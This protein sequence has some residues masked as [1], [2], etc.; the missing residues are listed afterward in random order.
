MNFHSI[1]T[2]QDILD[3]YHQLYESRNNVSFKYYRIA[4]KNFLWKLP[5]S[6]RQFVCTSSSN[7]TPPRISSNFTNKFN[8]VHHFCRSKNQ[9]TQCFRSSDTGDLFEK[10]NDAAWLKIRV[11]G[12]RF[13]SY[14]PRL[15]PIFSFGC[16]VISR[17]ESHGVNLFVQKRWAAFK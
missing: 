14:F 9:T 10:I 15:S 13:S 4:T 6:I 8:R 1:V 5:N 2:R 7:N 16:G 12:Q 11:S 17:G 3:M